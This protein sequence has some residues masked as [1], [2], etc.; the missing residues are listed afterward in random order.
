MIWFTADNHY[1]HNNII[2]YCDRPFKNINEMHKSL[3]SNH[4]AVVKSSDTVYFLGDFGMGK[5]LQ[6]IVS[7]LNGI[8]LIKSCNLKIK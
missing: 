8:N 5:L 6:N 3:I 2:H 7:Q 1:Y 4:N